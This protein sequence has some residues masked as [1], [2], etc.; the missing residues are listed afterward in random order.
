MIIEPHIAKEL[1]EIAIGMNAPTPRESLE[2]L[3]T[4]KRQEQGIP[5]E[6]N[7]EPRPVGTH[8]GARFIVHPR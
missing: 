5:C 8:V 2:Q 6:E 1:N 7:A 4:R 3:I